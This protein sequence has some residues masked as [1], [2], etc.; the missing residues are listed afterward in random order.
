MDD[1]LV[2]RSL[3]VMMNRKA[4]MLKMVEVVE[5]NMFEVEIDV[6]VE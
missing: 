1:N 6:D 3:V 2:V 4:L 5:D